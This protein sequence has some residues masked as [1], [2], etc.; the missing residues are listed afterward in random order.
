MIRIILKQTCPFLLYP[1]IQTSLV[2]K[3]EEVP[4]VFAILF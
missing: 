2:E 4:F 1:H 3:E